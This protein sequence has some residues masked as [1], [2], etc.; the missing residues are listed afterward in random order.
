VIRIGINLSRALSILNVLIIL[1]WKSNGR[2]V[3]GKI[4]VET[5]VTIRI[6]CFA[7]NE[8]SEKCVP[9]LNIKN[10]P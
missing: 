7:W 5:K 2:A 10:I 8:R 6:D 4:A 1:N 9:V 3:K